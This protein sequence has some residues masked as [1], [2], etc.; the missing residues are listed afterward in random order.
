MNHITNQAE[1]LALPYPERRAHL[2]ELGGQL[3]DAEERLAE[4]IRSVPMRDLLGVLHVSKSVYYG[5]LAEPG[6][7]NHRHPS[8]VQFWRICCFTGYTL[9]WI[10][11]GIGK[12][13]VWEIPRTMALADRYTDLA[14]QGPVIEAT[15]VA[16]VAALAAVESIPDGG[17]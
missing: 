1:W 2:M 5:W 6:K 11:S 10:C 8:L 7:S 15:R 16:L 4:A 9:D 17:E 13:F 12:K 3:S 14:N